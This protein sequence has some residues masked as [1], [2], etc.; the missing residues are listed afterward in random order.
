VEEEEAVSREIAEFEGSQL[1]DGLEERG[2]FARRFD[3]R[4]REVRRVLARF[5][6]DAEGGEGVFGVPGDGNQS[7]AFDSRPE[8]ARRVRI[9]KEAELFDGDGDGCA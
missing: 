4:K 5:F 6:F 3:A 8:N 7:V 1:G 2:L 9:G